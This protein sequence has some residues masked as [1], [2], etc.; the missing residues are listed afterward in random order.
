MLFLIDI[1][2]NILTANALFKCNA[3][4]LSNASITLKTDCISIEFCRN[5]S[6]FQF[7][8]VTPK[9]FLCPSTVS[10]RCKNTS[11]CD[12]MHEN[13]VSKLIFDICDSDH[14]LKI[15]NVSRPLEVTFRFQI[16]NK[17][18]IEKCILKNH[19]SSYYLKDVMYN[20][21]KA[22]ESCKVICTNCGLLLTENFI[23]FQSVHKYY[24]WKSELNETSF[25]H[26]HDNDD[27]AKIKTDSLY[28]DD[29]YF[30]FHY[31]MLVNFKLL[32]K[33]KTYKCN[34]CSS[35]LSFHKK[36]DNLQYIG[37]FCD[38][39]ML[40]KSHNDENDLEKHKI[41]TCLLSTF[42]IVHELLKTTLSPK[43]YLQSKV[44]IFVLDCLIY[45]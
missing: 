24:D 20:K 7:N 2:R 28:I 45:N 5:S 4:F 8:I 11:E 17:S 1:H 9:N 32:E 33:N 13:N 10:L 25:C 26:K 16:P 18:V 29:M 36:M 40:L 3:D 22:I 15:N 39:I 12:L 43:L 38:K 42:S 41:D 35:T 27:T 6:T 14:D 37:F 31:S 44:S 30:Y 34:K 23:K 19:A 21:Y